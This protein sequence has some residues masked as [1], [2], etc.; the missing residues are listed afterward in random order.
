MWDVKML[1]G[2]WLPSS[3]MFYLNYVGCKGIFDEFFYCLLDWFYLNYVGCKVDE[4]EL[5]LPGK[6]GFI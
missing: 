2:L 4:Q 6:V 5:K 3:P 1:R